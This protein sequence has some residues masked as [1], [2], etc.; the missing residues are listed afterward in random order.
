VIPTA[1]ATG[2]TRRPGI[3]TGC[4]L[5]CDDVVP[6]GDTLE[7]ACAAGQRAWSVARAAEGAARARCDGRAVTWQEGIARA[8]ADMAAARRVLFTGLTDA[9][10]DAIVA[11]CDLA[12]NRGAAIDAG[13][14]E[15]AATAGPVIARVGRVTADYDDLRD[16]SDLVVFWFCDPGTTHPRF[17]ERFVTPPVAGGI[18][19]TIAVGPAAV[20]PAGPSHLH[21]PLPD[22]AA[23]AAARALGGLW[24]GGTAAVQTE[25]TASLEPIHRALA[26]AGCAG[27]VTGFRED[28]TG[29]LSW[30]VAALVRDLAAAKPAFEVPLDRGV[31]GGADAAGVV[32]VCTWRYGAGGG[33]ARADRAGAAFRP[34]E[35][36]A[37]RLISRGEV[38]CV[39]AVG[40]L[41]PE[42][43]AAIA[44]RADELTLVRVSTT[45][46][47]AG[48]NGAWL[49]IDSPLVAATGA[50]LRGDGRW[51]PLGD[52]EPA[53][54]PHS[55]TSALRALA[56]GLSSATRRPAGGTP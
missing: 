52:A 54:A 19:R 11:A 37:L 2:M 43:E 50:M 46:G 40:G 13:L 24:K 49:R 44:E 47:P 35:A 1:A 6:R 12:E 38:D 45:D 36:D 5:L 30:A 41:P 22:A 27:I 23:L 51:V 16:R 14:P 55:A 42:I 8:V 48:T 39:V 4:S 7:G 29:L 9:T 33:I 18:R 20:L 21:V 56:A 3:C 28:P 17:V 53:S 26:A 15:A 10:I 31:G 32:A 25:L 34:A